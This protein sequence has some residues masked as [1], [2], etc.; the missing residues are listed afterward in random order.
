MIDSRFQSAYT[1]HP[2]VFSACRTPARI[3]LGFNG[4]E[5]GF[6]TIQTRQ[7]IV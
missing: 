2:D 6:S 5:A 4:L 7:F 3:G 1:A